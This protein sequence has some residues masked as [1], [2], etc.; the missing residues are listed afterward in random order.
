MATGGGAIFCYRGK[1]RVRLYRSRLA[2]VGVLV[3]IVEA[4]A[5]AAVA[6]TVIAW[7]HR[8]S[9]HEDQLATGVGVRGLQ[10]AAVGVTGS[11]GVMNL[12]GTGA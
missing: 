3:E 6:T 1:E 5:V 11:A 8:V 7:R 9:W 10:W 2:V 4:M 12:V